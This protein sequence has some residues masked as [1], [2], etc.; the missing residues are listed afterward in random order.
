MGIDPISLVVGA[1]VGLLTAGTSAIINN[2]NNKKLAAANKDAQE[3]QEAIEKAKR[4]DERQGIDSASQT[5]AEHG[6]TG[7]QKTILTAYK[8]QKAMSSGNTTLGGGS[9]IA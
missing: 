7:L 2:K 1:G 9:N 6:A 3:K 8:K 4:P 5:S